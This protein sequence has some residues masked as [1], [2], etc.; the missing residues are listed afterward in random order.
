MTTLVH[1][2]DGLNWTCECG[3]SIRFS[4]TATCGDV[5]DAIKIHRAEHPPTAE[6]I[7]RTVKRVTQV[8]DEI[9]L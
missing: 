6:E 9:R 5:E 4:D 7:A 3:Q 2:S 8:I 1:N